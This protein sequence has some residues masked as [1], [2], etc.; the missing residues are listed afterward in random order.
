MKICQIYNL[1]DLLVADKQQKICLTGTQDKKYKPSFMF[2]LYYA[3]MYCVQID[4]FLSAHVKIQQQF[5][6]TIAIN[7]RDYLCNRI[8]YKHLLEAIKIITDI[9]LVLSKTY[10]SEQCKTFKHLRHS[11][12]TH[13]WYYVSWMTTLQRVSNSACYIKYKVSCL[14]TAN[15]HNNFQLTP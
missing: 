2:V 11:I 3:T 10:H 4:N 1:L 8:N 15:S 6:R 5:K 13:I 14:P 12:Q 9:K 7:N